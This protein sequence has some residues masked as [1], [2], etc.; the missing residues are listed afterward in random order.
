MFVLLSDCV[1]GQDV[2]LLCYKLVCFIWSMSVISFPVFGSFMQAGFVVF[3]FGPF[4]VFLS[5]YILAFLLYN[6]T[7]SVC[8]VCP[9][10]P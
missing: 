10:A 8:Q 4:I 3:T 9:C 2:V 7:L 1:L 5:L 6:L